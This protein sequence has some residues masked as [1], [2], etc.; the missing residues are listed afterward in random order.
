[1]PPREPRSRIDRALAEVEEPV[2][3]D[4]AEQ[5]A[6]W[7]DED[8][9]QL[10]ELLEDAAS[11]LQREMLHR[12]LAAG[13][14]LRELHSFA[15][16]I[17]GLDDEEVFRECTPPRSG[18]PL[19]V[20]LTAQADPLAAYELN[21]NALHHAGRRSRRGGPPVKL[22]PQLMTERT[23]AP[24]R[25]GARFEASADT[26]AR[27]PDPR[28]LGRSGERAAPADPVQ[29]KFAEELFNEA[30]RALER[31]FNELAVDTGPFTLER[32]VPLL[33]DALSRGVPVPCIL[34]REP[35]DFRRYALFLQVQTSGRNRAYQLFDPVAQESVWANE[36]DL[37]N[38]IELPFSEKAHRRV[39]ALALPRLP[40][41]RSELR[42]SAFEDR[43]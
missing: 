5:V 11:D 26:D 28:E 12:G 16:A 19:N 38:R 17:R 24:A 18:F 14:P 42:D 1:M 8:R 15:D 9:A 10:I 33:A 43:G 36:G 25:G 32:A 29:G 39:T 35:G 21:G 4:S 13:R 2:L 34:G 22:P 23:W 40:P 37:L 41:N 3:G 31:R 30:G 7:D 6:D 20:L 27:A